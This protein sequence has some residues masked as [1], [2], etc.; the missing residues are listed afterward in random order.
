MTY[1][2]HRRGAPDERYDT[3]KTLDIQ[4]VALPDI[5]DIRQIERDNWQEVMERVSNAIKKEY[6]TFV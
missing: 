6:R 4:A 1:L 5:P 2:P 3:L